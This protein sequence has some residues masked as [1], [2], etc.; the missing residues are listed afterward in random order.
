MNI[1]LICGKAG[2]GKNEVADY[3]YEKLDNSVIT[4]FS[5]YIKMFALELTDWDGTDSHKPRKF[6]QEMGDNLRA[7]DPNF[8]TKRMKEDIE[9]YET[10]GIKNIIISD[11]RLLN[12]V[13]YFKKMKK[14]NVIT[15]RVNSA[16]STRVLTEEQKKHH[17]ETELDN[18][19]EYDYVIE[20]AFDRSL[21]DYVDKIVEGR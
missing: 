12:E 9:V 7:I 20:N 17:T 1:Y 11:V 21:Y 16:V 2:S 13:E 19:K 8:M 14:Y 6:L 10:Q 4:A 5:K 18:Y 15:I 3:L